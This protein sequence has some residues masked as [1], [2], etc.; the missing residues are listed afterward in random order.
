MA[1]KNTKLVIVESPSKIKTLKKFLGGD[2]IIE[3][4]VGHICDLSKKDMGIDIENGFTPTYEVSPD[5]KK[6][7]SNLKAVMKNVD[8]L[9]LATDPD[10]EGEAISWHLIEQ[11]KP[12]VPVKRLVFNEITKTAILEA[13][14]NTRE[15]DMSL[16]KAQETRRILDRLFGFM[17]SK[18]LWFNVKGGLSAGRVQSPAV[19]ILVDREK[20]RSR[21]IES[22]Y[23]SVSADF[24]IKGESFN[25]T[26][27]YIGTERVATGKSFEKETGALVQKNTLALDKEGAEKLA[28][29]LKDHD[30]KVSS[31]E[32]KP[33]TQNPYAPFITSTLQQEGIRKL[34]MSSQQVMRVAQRLYENGYITYMRTDSVNL[35]NEAITA[36]RSAISSMYGDEYMPKS[37]RQYKSNA[38]N[39]QEAHEAIRPAG[40]LFILP[41]ELKSKLESNEYKL[42]DLIWKRTVA[43][44]MSSAKLQKTSVAISD[45]EYKFSASGKIIEFPGFMRAYVEGADDP[46]AQLDDK[47]KKLPQMHEGDLLKCESVDSKQHFTKPI[48]RFT[49]ASLV[50]EL[51]ALG[52]GRPSTYASIM[53]RI[54]DKGYV[55]R[56]KGSMIPTFTGYAVIQFLEKYFDELVDL[57]YTSQMENILDE[58]SNG[59]TDSSKFLDEFYF[60][61]D[62]N[63][64]GLEADLEQEFDKDLSKEIMTIIDKDENPIQLKIG[65]YGLYIQK[66]DTRATI[67]DTIPP[68]ELDSN[69]VINLL[70]KKES[71]PEEMGNFPETGEPIYLKVGRY[72]PYI[73]TGKKMKSLLPGMKEEDVTPEIALAII[74]L[75]K[76][77]GTW[78]ENGKAIISDIG[79]FG[80][81]IKCEKETRSIPASINLLEITEEQ[82]CELL[83]IK[84]KGAT[85]ILKELGDGIELKDGRYGAYV[86]D[87]K[88][89]ATLPKS[90]SPDDITLE[91]AIQLIAEKKAKGPVKKYRKKKKK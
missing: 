58:I 24:S 22:E 4:S 40:S 57:Q 32:Q 81:Y 52:I 85:S 27:N 20:E 71:G 48:N 73:Q 23:W 18:K 16:F 51:E 34:R 28:A 70:E 31:L 25:T 59:S 38:K 75:P 88:I 10:R 36:A 78:P 21:F 1:N 69:Y 77:I 41:D 6:V 26:L 8:E 50:K 74:S 80:P 72:G 45:G 90:T 33:G 43:S 44:Q 84:R 5:S 35:S 3:A 66:G 19:K 67:L 39:A 56:V 13:F 14:N 11:L 82:A 83:A 47:E 15:L 53:K 30:W 2:Y 17:V 9:Y 62:K 68:S 65:R 29:N 86:T 46:N 89:N 91:I 49:E 37:P 87:G 42:Y 7:V 63:H 79:R 76:T 12:K 60:G 61:T 55:N 54:Q 64:L